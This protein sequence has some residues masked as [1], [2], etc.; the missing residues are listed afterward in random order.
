MIKKGQLRDK[1]GLQIRELLQDI[2]EPSWVRSIVDLGLGRR[3]V[4]R[5]GEPS[6]AESGPFQGSS[7]SSES[8]WCRLESGTWSY[9][10][11]DISS[12]YHRLY[13]FLFQS[14]RLGCPKDKVRIY[15]TTRYTPSTPNRDLRIEYT[16]LPISSGSMRLLPH[17]RVG[18][19]PSPSIQIIPGPF[20]RL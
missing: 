20:G 5:M 12:S 14:A 13:R 15:H 10:D 4:Q 1:E 6:D 9:E 3:K 8:N 2:S 11:A 16:G 18:H 7:E 17:R 19:P